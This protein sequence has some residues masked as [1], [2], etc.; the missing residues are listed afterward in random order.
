MTGTVSYGT[1]YDDTDQWLD[2]DGTVYDGGSTRN[3]HH[4]ERP[5]DD[6]EPDS[7]APIDLGPY[8]RGEI[9]PAEPSIG[10]SRTDGLRLLYPGK[11]HAVI[12]E[13]ESGKSWFCLACV[14]AELAADHHVVYIH[15]EESDPSDT[16]E[17]LI[18]LGCR[19]QDI[20]RLLRFV[21]PERKVARDALAALLDPPPSL[22]VLD[23]VNEAMAL[24]G[25]GIRDEDGAA[26]F[27]RRLVKPC[28]SVGAATLATD[29]VVKNPENVSGKLI[30]DGVSS[31]GSC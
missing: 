2:R 14:A 7:W 15:F 8:L 26:E 17:R 20:L 30:G 21:G 22:V 27:R 25:W 4:T 13:M 1:N 12:G 10:V 23:G 18:T 3:G 16:L 11:E 19:D 6:P 24:H 31:R 29:H 5:D 28:T 9:R